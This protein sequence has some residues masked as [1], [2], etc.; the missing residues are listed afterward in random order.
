[1]NGTRCIRDM[2][3]LNTKD[4]APR[5]TWRRCA[6]W[7]P[8]RCTAIRL[9]QCENRVAGPPERLRRR[10]RFLIKKSG[11]KESTE[12]KS[13]QKK[14]LENKNALSES[15]NGFMK[16]KWKALC[17]ILGAGAAFQLLSVSK[18]FAQTST[19][20]TVTHKQT[21]TVLAATPPM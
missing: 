20:T 9:R 10:C 11:W 19:A 15:R 12:G 7:V 8:R 3:W 1:M 2:G 13:T 6:N 5:N 21:N 18:T 17:W 14:H 16:I 4:T